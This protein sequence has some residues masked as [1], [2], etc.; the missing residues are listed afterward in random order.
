MNDID[1]DAFG[2]QRVIPDAGDYNVMISAASLEPNKQRNGSN[3]VIAYSI[4]DGPFQGSEKTEYLSVIHK[5]ADA[6]RIS[7]SRLKAIQTVTGLLAE[8]KGEISDLV[9]RSL[10]IRMSKEPHQFTN[11]QGQVVK[12]YQ[13]DVVNYMTTDG[14]DANGKKVPAFVVQTASA[15]ESTG[16]QNTGGSSSSSNSGSSQSNQGSGSSDMDDEIP[17]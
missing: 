2:G 4:I 17:F 15:N 5:S 8:G 9:G 6:Q 14:E 12:T 1:G 3:A 10:R 13:N 16:N 7:R 11:T